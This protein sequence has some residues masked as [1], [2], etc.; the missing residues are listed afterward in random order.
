MR[1]KQMPIGLETRQVHRRPKPNAGEVRERV[2]TLSKR[3]TE[4]QPHNAHH[5]G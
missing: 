1:D 4:E 5:G 2:E 3:W